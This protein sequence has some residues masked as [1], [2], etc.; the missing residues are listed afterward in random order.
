MTGRLVTCLL[1][2][3]ALPA[4]AAAQ[5][6]E[7]AAAV[8][9]SGVVYHDRNENGRRDAGEPGLAGVAVTDQVAVVRTDAEGRF[10]FPAAGYGYVAVTPPS[11]FAARRGWYRPAGTE[12][13]EVP[14]VA[15]PTT[16]NFTFIHA[17]DTHISPAT[18][19]RIRRLRTLVDSLQPAFVI[20]SG[21]LVRDALR[22]PEAEARGYYD[23]LVAELARFSVPVFTVPG[24]HENFGIERHRSL[25]SPDHPLYGK[26]MYRAYFGPN[27]YSFDWGGIHF[28]GLDTVDYFD[29]SYY[30]HVDAVQLAW[31]DADL[32]AAA[33]RPV[34]TFN[35]IPLLTGALTIDGYDDESVA[36][37]L[38]KVAGK[39][40]FRHTVR[41]AD[42]VL[43]RIGSRLEIA[44]G[45]HLHRF[46]FIRYQTAHGFRRF[47]LAP[48][49]V[50]PPRGAG[51]LGI[52]SGLTLY[53]V[54]DRR[55]DDGTF[56]P[57][58]P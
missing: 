29:I 43:S 55:V 9:V 10:A 31:L 11:E 1:A 53:R 24:N 26:K 35:H 40:A 16:G 56:I 13:I 27:F 57:L 58:E 30:G 15:R 34:V 44:L 46:E 8:S 28:V 42:S 47:A 12:P 22:V 50:G 32:A 25:V 51:E 23:L 2:S 49:I 54:T 48:A 19:D 45:G 37:T 38:F 18:V 4:V 21:D 7:R 3:A 14:L 6:A 36:P 39:T 41:N 52:R 5:P 33:D 20:L 17:S